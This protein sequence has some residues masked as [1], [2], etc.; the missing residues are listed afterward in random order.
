MS[1][2]FKHDREQRQQAVSYSCVLSG[3]YS[4]TYVSSTF[5]SSMCALAPRVLLYG[6]CSLG[7]GRA[8]YYRDEA[9]LHIGIAGVICADQ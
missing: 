3:E 9:K 1:C 2:D 6:I 7:V 5:Y 4:H 8:K